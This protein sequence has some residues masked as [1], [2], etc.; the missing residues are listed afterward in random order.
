M[1]IVKQPGNIYVQLAKRNLE[2]RVV[3]TILAAVGI[4]I[5][6]FAISS[7]GILGN[8]LKVSV[9][10]SF[11]DYS[12]EIIIYPAGGETSITENQVKQLDKISGIESVVPIYSSG[13][14][15]EFKDKSIYG[16]VYG[17]EN[18]DL[19][20]LVEVDDG[21]MLKSSSTNCVIGPELASFL[22]IKVGGK[23]TLEDTK[24]KVIG[25][26]KK[27]GMSPDISVDNSIFVN[28]EVYNKIFIDNED[29]YD[30]VI[31]KA[32]NVDDV[33]GMENSVKKVLN[34]KD[35]KVFLSSVKS[36]LSSVEEALRYVSL[37]LMGIGSISLVVASVSILNVMLMSVTERTKEIGIMK[38]VGASRN[39]IMKMFILESLI[40]G[41]IA[42]FIG[43]ILSL[44]VVF[45]ITDLILK[46]VSSLFDRDVILYII[47]AIGFG[48]ITSLTGGV[49][50]ALKASKLKPID[51]LKYQ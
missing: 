17:I 37:F 11:E 1:K 30:F 3:R 23:V 50:P 51:S 31:V 15:I 33:D 20:S 34:K 4:I 5:G 10:N 39:D 6:V 43:G 28:P 29:E 18:E 40:L 16:A 49:Y 41:I 24:L 42:S 12:N 36:M 26:L 22:D 14:K 2:R 13:T 48:I 8:C 21:K 47:G 38:A 25:I 45:V 27:R 9:S 19:I 46:D 32:K 44:G 35:D 7:M